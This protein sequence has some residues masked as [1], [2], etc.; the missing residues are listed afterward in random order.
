MNNFTKYMIIFS[1]VLFSMFS[2][3]N[4]QAKEGV[5]TLRMHQFLPSQA[6]EPK[7]ILYKWA[8]DVE[9]ASGGRIK[10]EHYDSMAL[11]GSPVDL[12]DQAVD[13]IA[14]IIW[15]LPGY[16]AGR[17]PETEVFELPFMMSDAQATS[18]AFWDFGQKWLTKGSMKDTHILALWVHG[19][20]EI[21]SHKA[22][23]ALEDMRGLKI[24]TPNRPMNMYFSEIGAEPIGMPVPAVPE[25]LTKHVI[26]AAALPWA[27]TAPLKT[28]EMV[29]YHTVFTHK[30]LY[31]STFVMTMNKERYE[32]L[33]DDLKAVIDQHSGADFSS[34]AGGIQIKYDALTFEN[35]KKSDNII[36]ELSEQEISRWQDAAKRTYKQWAEEM[37]ALG[38]DGQAMIEEAKSAI[39]HYNQ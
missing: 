39:D 8:R 11:G 30:P 24:R 7:Y 37:D 35:T 23:K 17:F 15:T 36:I 20:G 22:I 34:Y 14:D 9:K 25:S 4:A 29:D 38:F 31:T 5:I 2:F 33:P 27:V 3:Q 32:A 1:L 10:I 21:H 12:Y 19:P 26:D 28:A 6:V 13:G 16:T 18:R